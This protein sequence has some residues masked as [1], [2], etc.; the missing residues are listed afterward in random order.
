MKECI[1]WR[2]C[3]ESSVLIVIDVSVECRRVLSSMVS[4]VFTPH[5]LSGVMR[6]TH[7]VSVHFNKLR[8]SHID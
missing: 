5:A 7:P 4:L 2:I 3:R 8:R 6:F 1:D